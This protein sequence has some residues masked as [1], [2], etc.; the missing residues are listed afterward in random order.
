MTKLLLN[1][2][3][4][5]AAVEPIVGD[6]NT[7]IENE[8]ALKDG[9]ETGEDFG[10]SA[11]LIDAIKDEWEA[12]DAYN[13][14][15]SNVGDNEEIKKII[16]DINAEENNH[17]GMLQ[18][19]LLQL[20]PVTENIKEGE[21]EAVETIDDVADTQQAWAKDLREYLD[22]KGRKNWSNDDYFSDAYVS[23]IL[24]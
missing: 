6:I 5:D 3:L 10:L 2:E 17:V 19:A 24:A 16:Q 14:L 7:Q 23:N 9:P 11:L 15:L 8:D 12:I 1:E 13:T 18:Q 4:F 21:E 20:S 22:T